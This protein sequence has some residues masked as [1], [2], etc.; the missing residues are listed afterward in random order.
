MISITHKAILTWFT[1]AKR[2]LRRRFEELPSKPGK[3]STDIGIYY[4]ITICILVS[5]WYID[6]T[7]PSARY[8]RY[9]L[10]Y[11]ISY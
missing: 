1:M 2:L 3:V 6:T 11:T 4:T 10:H 8:R 5:L 7:W 9:T